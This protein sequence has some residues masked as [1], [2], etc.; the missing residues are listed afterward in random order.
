MDMRI[1]FGRGVRA[2]ALW[3]V[4]STAWPAGAAVDL[5]LQPVEDP[6]VVGQTL[7][8]ALIATNDAAGEVQ[9]VSAITAV[10]VWDPA[11]FG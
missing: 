3:V 6:V 10:F 4:L 11:V 8:V 5:S 7:S 1:R 9:L 2:G